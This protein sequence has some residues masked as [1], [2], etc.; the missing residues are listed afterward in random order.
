MFR[1]IYRG[2]LQASLQGV[3]YVQ[4]LVF[5]NIRDLVLQI[6]LNIFV[7]WPEDGSVYVPKHVAR[8]T[9]KTYNRY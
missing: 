5:W 4:L 6:V 2:H 3:L 7:D 9:T 1:L 8:K